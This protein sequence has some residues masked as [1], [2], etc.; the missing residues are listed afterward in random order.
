MNEKRKIISCI[1]T[2]LTKVTDIEFCR[3]L[4]LTKYVARPKSI[5]KKTNTDIEWF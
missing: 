3:Y 4:S 2:K 1:L 5:D